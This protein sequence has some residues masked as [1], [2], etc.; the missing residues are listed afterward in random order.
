VVVKPEA[1]V[2][3]HQRGFQHFW[4]CKSRVGRTKLPKDL[5]LLIVELVRENPTW[6][7]ARIAAE[8]A[9]KLGIRVSP[10]T[11]RAYWPRA[12]RPDRTRPQ[13]W[14]TFVRNHAKAMVACDFAVAVT[15]HFRF[16]VFS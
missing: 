14:T 12:L 11:V 10:R 2:S 1:L 4:R 16:F 3:W 15:L 5:R 13:R 6:G 8:L 9:L 7:E